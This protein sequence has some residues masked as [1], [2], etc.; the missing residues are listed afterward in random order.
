[1]KRFSDKKHCIVYEKGEHKH[2]FMFGNSDMQLTQLFR[3]FGQL[4]VDP[5]IDFSW[6]DANKLTKAVKEEVSNGQPNN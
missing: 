4:T 2:I 3:R 1:M 6:R 5:D